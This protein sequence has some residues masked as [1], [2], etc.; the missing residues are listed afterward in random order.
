MST[1]KYYQNLKVFIS[2]PSSL[3]LYTSTF[4][5]IFIIETGQ[6]Y[7]LALGEIHRVAEILNISA[8]LYIPWILS[9]LVNPMDIFACFEE[10]RSQWLTSGLDEALQTLSRSIDIAKNLHESI[11]Y[12]RDLDL[13]TLDFQNNETTQE[14]IC[15]LSL[16]S[17]KTVPGKQ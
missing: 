17:S 9:S 13:T 7:I 15:K 11:T 4:I 2:L 6:Q 1:R 5:F 8:T 3:Y 10:C 12:I 14:H 16:S